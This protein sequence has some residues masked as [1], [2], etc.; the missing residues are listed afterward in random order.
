M[1]KRNTDSL[2]GPTIE[3]LEAA[4][5]GE[6]QQEV[7]DAKEGEKSVFHQVFA[8]VSKMAGKAIDATT[9]L[10]LPAGVSLDD[11][12]TISR[13]YE[14]VLEAKRGGKIIKGRDW[15]RIVKDDPNEEKDF[16][17]ILEENGSGNAL[18]TNSDILVFLLERYLPNAMADERQ[19]REIRTWFLFDLGI[20][21]YMA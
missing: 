1:T 10:K 15:M 12:K 6:M 18:D 8:W 14:K 21:S 3:D 9:E 2:R 19:A 13:M 5:H 16:L 4:V 11:Y 20:I 17:Q 7:K